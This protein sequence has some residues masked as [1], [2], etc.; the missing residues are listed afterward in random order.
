M[1]GSG[2]GEDLNVPDFMRQS[3]AEQTKAGMADMARFTAWYYH[4][5]IEENV[6]MMSATMIA[7]SYVAA[8]VSSAVQGGGAKEED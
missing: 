2:G 1:S 3:D 6:P 4:G 5:L 7:Q 8:M